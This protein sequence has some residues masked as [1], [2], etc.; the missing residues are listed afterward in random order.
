MGGES[1][2]RERLRIDPKSSPM[3]PRPIATQVLPATMDILMQFP[4]RELRYYA[5]SLEVKI[6]ARISKR[7]LVAR[8]MVKDPT[9]LAQLGN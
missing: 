6:E 9:V 1:Y 4:M 2:A 7:V 3:H 5:K 8:I